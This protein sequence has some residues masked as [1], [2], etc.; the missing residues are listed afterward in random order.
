MRASVQ[1]SVATRVS[2]RRRDCF[3]AKN[4][5][6]FL[7]HSFPQFTSHGQRL[8]L[9]YSPKGRFLVGDRKIR[10]RFWNA[11]GGRSICHRSECP[12]SPRACE[13]LRTGLWESPS[14]QCRRV[15]D[16]PASWVGPSV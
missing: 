5:L 3:R 2:N 12:Q 10:I 9:C 13:C 1:C 8:E 14:E 6:F 15:P 4:A 7:C 11:Y 16:S